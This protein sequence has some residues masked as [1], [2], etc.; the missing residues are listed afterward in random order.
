MFTAN[1]NREICVCFL[2][3]NSTMCKIILASDANAKQLNST[4]K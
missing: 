2:E 4:E 1:S 3:K